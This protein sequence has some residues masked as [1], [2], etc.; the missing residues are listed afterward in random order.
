MKIKLKGYD[1]KNNIVDLPKPLSYEMH[2]G[3]Y[4]IDIWFSFKFATEICSSLIRLEVIKENGKVFSCFIDNIK[5]SLSKQGDYFFLKARSMICRIWQNQV[6][7]IEYKTYNVLAMF[8]KYARPYG[9]NK[10]KFNTHKVVLNNFYV[11]QG[12]PNLERYFCSR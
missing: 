7:P 3:E 10:L 9:I 12:M 2:F 4:G 5:R 11:E 6:R 8:D 1:I